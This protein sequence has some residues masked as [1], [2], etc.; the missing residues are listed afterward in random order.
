MFFSIETTSRAQENFWARAPQASTAYFLA[1]DH[2]IGAIVIDRVGLAAA[3][4]EP[5]ASACVCVSACLRVCVCV[6]VRACVRTGKP[7]QKSRSGRAGG[8]LALDWNDGSPTEELTRRSFELHAEL[9][10][11]LAKYC[12]EGDSTDYRRLTCEAIALSASRRR[13]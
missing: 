13:L 9:G 10:D 2:G 5:P 12:D 6:C 8:F 7:N 3:A 11:E 4:H 1:R